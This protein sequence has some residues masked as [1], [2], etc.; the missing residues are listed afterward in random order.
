MEGGGRAP[1]GWCVAGSSGAWGCSFMLTF[2]HFLVELGLYA[3]DA[4][5][6]QNFLLWWA[7]QAH[8]RNDPKDAYVKRFLIRMSDTMAAVKKVPEQ[9]QV[10]EG[11]EV[12]E[13]ELQADALFSNGM[14][15][16]EQ[17]KVRHVIEEWQKRG[18]Y[19]TKQI[20]DA[21]GRAF[22]QGGQLASL[23]SIIKQKQEQQVHSDDNR[24]TRP[25]R[26]GAYDRD[27][28]QRDDAGANNHRRYD[29]RREDNKRYDHRDVG[30]IMGDAPG[31]PLGGGRIRRAPD[32]R[33]NDANDRDSKKARGSRWGPPKLDNDRPAPIVT[34]LDREGDYRL[35]SGRSGYRSPPGSSHQTPLL[36]SPRGGAPR[37]EEWNKNAPSSRGSGAGW[38]RD[39]VRSPQSGGL[40]RQNASSYDQGSIQRSPFSGSD[41][42][43]SPGNR[44]PGTSGELCRNFLSGIFTTRKLLHQVVVG[45]KQLNL[46]AR[47]CCVTTIRWGSVALEIS[48]GTIRLVVLTFALLGR[49]HLGYLVHFFLMDRTLITDSLWA[50]HFAVYVNLY[51]SFAH[52]EDEL[53]KSARYPSRPPVH[54]E[55]PG[56]RWQPSPSSRPGMDQSRISPSA[57][58]PAPSSQAR[59]YGASQVYNEPHGDRGSRGGDSSVSYANAAALSPGGRRLPSDNQSTSTA[60]AQGYPGTYT[61]ASSPYGAP[62]G[63]SYTNQGPS[64]SSGADQGRSHV[65]GV[66]VLP[67]PGAGSQSYGGDRATAPAPSAK[68]LPDDDDGDT[69]EPEFT[70]DSSDAPDRHVSNRSLKAMGLGSLVIVV[71]VMQILSLLSSDSPGSIRSAELSAA[72]KFEH[73]FATKTKYWNQRTI[74]TINSEAISTI[75]GE[76][77]L[78][79]AMFPLRVLATSPDQTPSRQELELVQTQIVARHGTRFD[80]AL[81]HHKHHWCSLMSMTFI[82]T[83]DYLDDLKEFYCIGA[84]YEINYEMAAVLLREIFDTMTARATG[85]STLLGNFFFA[86]AET[87]LPLITLMGFGDRTPLQSNATKDS[88]ATR[89]FRTSTLSPF[90]ANIEFRLFKRKS[91]GEEFYVQILVNEKEIAIPACGQVYCTL[92]ELEEHWHY[93]LKVYD[94]E[95][96]SPSGL[97]GPGVSLEFHEAPD[98]EDEQATAAEQS[99]KKLFDVVEDAFNVVS[100]S[101]EYFAD[102]VCFYDQVPR[103]SSDREVYVRFSIDPGNIYV[104]TCPFTCSNRCPIPVE[105]SLPASLTT[106]SGGVIVDVEVRDSFEHILLGQCRTFLHELVSNTQPQEIQLTRRRGKTIC[107]RMGLLVS[108]NN[109]YKAFTESLLN[110]IREFRCLKDKTD[111]QENYHLV[112]MVLEIEG[113]P[114]HLSPVVEVAAGD[115]MKYRLRTD[116]ATYDAKRSVFVWNHRFC[117]QLSLAQLRKEQLSLTMINEDEK[118]QSDSFKEL[119]STAI[120]YAALNPDGTPFFEWLVLSSPEQNRKICVAGCLLARVADAFDPSISAN[121]VEL[122]SISSKQQLVEELPSISLGSLLE[123][124]IG[125][126]CSTSVS[127]GESLREFM[128]AGN[129]KI[130]Q[131]NLSGQIQLQSG[132]HQRVVRKSNVCYEAAHCPKQECVRLETDTKDPIVLQ[133]ELS[134]DV[135]TNTLPQLSLNM[136]SRS[137]QKKCLSLRIALPYLL[138]QLSRNMEEQCILQLLDR[139]GRACGH[140]RATFRSGQQSQPCM[141]VHHQPQTCILSV[142]LVNIEISKNEGQ[143]MNCVAKVWSS[144]IGK[145]E[146]H[147]I[148]PLKFG[149]GGEISGNN[150]ISLKVSD[151]STEVFFLAIYRYSNHERN[152]LIGLGSFCIYPQ[153]LPGGNSSERIQSFEQFVKLYAE[154]ESKGVERGSV[155]LALQTTNEPSGNESYASLAAIELGS[156]AY[157]TRSEKIK[158]QFDIKLLEVQQLPQSLSCVDSISIHL[159]IAQSSW[160]AELGPAKVT[161]AADGNTVLACVN[162]TIRTAICWSSKDRSFPVLEVL[163]YAQPDQ[164]L[165]RS[166]I[167]SKASLVTNSLQKRRQVHN[168]LNTTQ[169]A[170]ESSTPELVATG[171]LNLCSFFSQLDVSTRVNMELEKEKHGG[172]ASNRD[173]MDKSVRILATFR[174]STY[175]AAASHSLTP[176]VATTLAPKSINGDLSSAEPPVI[177]LTLYRS[178]IEL[179]SLAH[180]SKS[181]LCSPGDQVVGN[182]TL[183]IFPSVFEDDHLIKF[184]IPFGVHLGSECDSVNTE[185]DLYYYKQ[186]ML[187]LEMQFL[188]WEQPKIKPPVSMERLEL[189]IHRLRGHLLDREATQR[190]PEIATHIF[191]DISVMQDRGGSAEELGVGTTHTI[192]ISPSGMTEVGEIVDLSNPIIATTLLSGSNNVLVGKIRDLRGNYYGRVHLPLRSDWKERLVHH[193]KQ[194]WCP[195][196]IE[197]K[198]GITATKDALLLSLRA[199]E[200]NSCSTKHAHS[201]GKF[202][203]KVCDAVLTTGIHNSSLLTLSKYRGANVQ[204]MYTSSN[205][206]TEI[207]YRTRQP[208]SQSNS[209]SWRWENEWFWF[210]HV[211]GQNSTQHLQLSMQIGVQANQPRFGG[212]VNM[213]SIVIDAKLR[214]VNFWIPLNETSSSED[215]AAR[216]HL[217]IVVVYIPTVVGTI[218]MDFGERFMFPEFEHN[219]QVD[220]MFYKCAFGGAT[221]DTTTEDRYADDVSADDNKRLRLPVDSTYN[222]SAEVPEFCIQWI[223]VTRTLGEIC[224]GILSIDFLAISN[225][226]T[227][228]QQDIMSSSTENSFYW[229]EFYDKAD[230]TKII[231]VAKVRMAF[232]RALNNVQHQSSGIVRSLESRVSSAETFTIWKKLFYV[233]DHNSN[234]YVDRN[235]FTNVFMNHADGMHQ[236]LLLT[237]EG[238]EHNTTPNVEATF[239][240]SKPNRELRRKQREDKRTIFSS[241]GEQGKTESNQLEVSP[242]DQ[243]VY[244]KIGL[245]KQERAASKRSNK[246]SSA[247][248]KLVKLQYS[249]QEQTRLQDQITSLEAILAIERRRYA[250]LAA[251]RQALVRSYQQLHLK[252]QNEIIQEQS[253]AKWMKQTIERQQQQLDNR[254]TDRKNRTHASIVLQSTVRSRLEQKRYQGLRLQRATAA[255]AIQCMMRQRALLVEA[256][257]VSA[258]ILQKNGRRM[259]A[260]KVW[261]CQKQSVAR[262]Q[263]WIRQRQAIMCAAEMRNATAVVKSAVLGWFARWQYTR[264]MNSARMLQRWWRYASKE[265]SAYLEL[266][267]AVLCIQSA[268]KRRSAREW[269]KREWQRQETYI[270]QLEAAICI[271]AAWRN[272]HQFV[273]SIR[274]RKATPRCGDDDVVKAVLDDIVTLL[275]TAIATAGY[276][277]DKSESKATSDVICFDEGCEAVLADI[278]TFIET[279]VAIA[280]GNQEV[281]ESK[282]KSGVIC[283][284]EEFVY[285][286][287]DESGFSQHNELASIS[288]LSSSELGDTLAALAD[289]VDSVV[290]SDEDNALGG[291][292]GFGKPTTAEINPTDIRVNEIDPNNTQEVVHSPVVNANLSGQE[293]TTMPAEGTMD[294]SAFSRDIVLDESGDADFRAVRQVLEDT[295]DSV[296][297]RAATQKE[298]IL[299]PRIND[300]GEVNSESIEDGQGR[301]NGSVH[302]LHW[303]KAAENLQEENVV[304]KQAA[305]SLTRTSQPVYSPNNEPPQSILNS[306]LDALISAINPVLTAADEM[307]STRSSDDIRPTPTPDETSITNVATSELH[308]ADEET[309]EELLAGWKENGALDSDR[310]TSA[311]GLDRDAEGSVSSSPQQVADALQELDTE[312]SNNDKMHSSVDD[313]GKQSVDHV[314]VADILKNESTGEQHGVTAGNDPAGSTDELNGAFDADTT[315]VGD[316]TMP[317]DNDSDEAGSQSSGESPGCSSIDSM[318]LMMEADAM[319]FMQDATGNDQVTVSDQ[320]VRR[321]KTKRL[322]S[323]KLL[324]DLDKLDAP[325][326]S[327]I[328]PLSASNETVDHSTNK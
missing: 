309:R 275:E 185:N 46:G 321:R 154:P 37:N 76:A 280:G 29:E 270:S 317:N 210:P 3:I 23:L 78:T 56:S 40:G 230:K 228:S 159:R 272:Q 248:H 59:S 222:T 213:S 244:P 117:F 10:R 55:Q 315:A 301:T 17:P 98:R 289:L 212:S 211:E 113:L 114:Q 284:D 142:K 277:Q 107:G 21:G 109:D 155:A 102:L 39:G 202:H 203:V 20:E 195:I 11:E 327:E 45:Q 16:M 208:M 303:N 197:A 217:H 22:L 239:Q 63:S 242:E 173:D 92:P 143:I 326:S 83:L 86:H 90:A 74:S 247:E 318:D 123:V 19:T 115:G 58:A 8:A 220:A 250:E 308:E 307:H 70:L 6:R 252:H 323:M 271:Q 167:G 94:F 118:V 199:C 145:A 95:K 281:G 28:R 286:S 193:R 44:I 161:R 214:R 47:R 207:C 126:I 99:K 144:T 140:L 259:I 7:E 237:I 295:L 276:N 72:D 223:G 26:E 282:T 127:E 130:Q 243:R 224:L 241:D 188:A 152:E 150:A 245:M 192:S 316:F 41:D 200:Q 131:F 148:S 324:A 66:P 209:K 296:G 97:P 50:L 291:E 285:L 5:I 169:C 106:E 274:S 181:A 288:D 105:M 290:H 13:E 91:M 246:V 204:L 89:G 304:D 121:A 261:Q 283:F 116:A 160:K 18:I 218:Q 260:S 2:V 81:Y 35:D 54:G 182:S 68:V 267:E 146:A 135:V 141:A 176:P 14:G 60:P 52:G 24:Q 129:R 322:D 258:T 162:D 175:Q 49:C 179:G 134:P 231:G 201:A 180:E 196:C 251:D 75:S 103:D 53:D 71:V 314:K 234:G 9:F 235:E 236:Q 278:V 319:A 310:M 138:N 183:P 262:L 172:N 34:S 221:Y 216:V 320:T 311:S 157:P 69:V 112:M 33:D 12:A 187:T 312:T 269:F 125:F 153:Y 64:F 255:T 168:G 158:C 137:P 265:R 257:N 198:S 206:E 268:W 226:Y 77:I 297:Y 190:T 132:V 124:V 294:N 305:K 65:P 240:Q 30:G 273:V 194:V 32:D 164:L 119:G 178:S 256:R 149:E 48:A 62:G 128:G 174:A 38:P 151:A 177:H 43:R 232:E 147:M 51:F 306:T 227:L 238:S 57:N 120:K 25:P 1:I 225:L 42:R 299:S 136:S 325:K 205:P 80:I 101:V 67:S 79:R 263:C 85:G 233:L 4:I 313:G 84:G 293:T 229:H 254:E 249:N 302:E 88:I 292:G 279:D 166:G 108:L 264:I 215:I 111:E 15:L 139:E 219:L 266:L 184:D 93:Y 104:S 122:P 31:V 100:F 61:T 287:R 253:K 191:V 82:H 298:G 163:V 300:N 110:D 165:N 36:Q 27:V 87:T 186:G 171:R 133:F 328:P 73:M 189:E 96:D 170:R 156:I